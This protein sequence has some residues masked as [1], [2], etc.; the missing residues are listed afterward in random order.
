MISYFSQIFNQDITADD[1]ETLSLED[2]YKVLDELQSYKEVYFSKWRKIPKAEINS[3]ESL[4]LLED[5]KAYNTLFIIAKRRAHY[6]NHAKVKQL[7]TATI[8]WKKRAYTLG[9][10]LGMTQD[11]VKQIQ[12][13]AKGA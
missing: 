7:T 5:M 9:K 8:I 11:Q 3:E 13:Y 12:V 6:L 10:E 4:S 1:L 2:T